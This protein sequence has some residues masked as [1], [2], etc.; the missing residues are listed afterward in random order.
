MTT[1]SPIRKRGLLQNVDIP[2]ITPSLYDL[3][4]PNDVTKYF[5]PDQT[6]GSCLGVKNE[7]PQFVLA[8]WRSLIYRN[9]DTP[10]DYFDDFTAFPHMP[11]DTS[12]YDCRVAEIM[13]DWMVSIPARIKDPTKYQN[14]TAL[15]GD[16]PAYSNYDP[17]PYEEVLPSDPDYAAA[18]GAAATRMSQYHLGYRY[19]FCP[20]EYKADIVD[21]ITADQVATNQPVTSDV[22]YGFSDP[23]NPALLIMPILAPIRPDYISYDVTDPPGAWFPRRPDWGT[24][25]VDPAL[26]TTLDPTGSTA[27]KSYIT[28]ETK[29]GDLLQNGVEDLTNVIEALENVTLTSDVRNALLKP[30]PFG[31]WDTSDT[32][33]NFSGE[34]V[35]SSFTGA[36]RPQWMSVLP[37]K[38]PNAP[39]FVESSGAAVFTTVCFNCHGINADSQGLLADEINTLTGGDAR[40]ANFRDGILGPT[41]APGTNRNSIFSDAATMLS[42]TGGGTVTTDD[43]A[44][45]YVAWMA[46][47]GT[48]KHLPEDVLAEVALSPVLGKIRGHVQSQG[49]PDMLRL[50]LDLCKQIA[51]SDLQQTQISLSQFVATG[52]MGWSSATGLVDKNGDAEMW[53]R[54]CNL[55]NRPFVRVPSVS[56]GKWT[57]GTGAGGL[58]ITGSRLYWAVGPNGE[59]W[60]GANPVMDQLGNV[61]NGVTSTYLTNGVT[62]PNLFPICVQKPTNAT[63]LQVATQA[64]QASPVA[65]KNVIPFCP[66]GLQTPNGVPFIDP[67]HLLAVDST[68]ASP[69]FQDGVKWAA[70]G[71]INAALAV[72]LYLDQIERD[73][74]MRQPLYTQCNL[75]G[76]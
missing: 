71:A 76:K 19:G 60:Y 16:F 50:G 49:T 36:D 29:S 22:G 3:P 46:L 9:T 67:S 24:A 65:G 75:I 58:T 64:L 27:V 8:P 10:Y 40:V 11:L 13:G 63:E 23:T 68:G 26:H 28:Q 38:D 55:S 7:G 32:T 57:P 51:T 14:V 61:N 44:A 43:L 5:C 25:L 74:S 56:G 54:L 70:R 66:D 17:Q 33:C 41:N 37:P 15:S 18:V 53:L 72:F 73:P 47:G 48:A 30:Y 34:R 4:S 62:N 12:G 39:V 2:Y 59:D 1:V 45:R 31:L 20:P 52:Q 69:D 42:M 21:P 35:A 6:N